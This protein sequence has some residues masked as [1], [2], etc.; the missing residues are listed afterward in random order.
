M[1]DLTQN[2]SENNLGPTKPAKKNKGM[3]I[4]AVVACV[5]AIA[6]VG[7]LLW[8]LGKDKE[9]VVENIVENDIQDNTQQEEIGDE[10]AEI[11][12]G[13]SSVVMPSD[14]NSMIASLLDVH[15]AGCFRVSFGAITNS[16][17]SP[18]QTVIGSFGANANSEGCE[19]ARG[20]AGT[21]LYRTSPDAE[22]QL[23]NM[24][25]DLLPCSAY[26]TI[27]RKRA[28]ADMKCGLG[29]NRTEMVSVGSLL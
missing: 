23:F 19:H 3:I 16:S 26:D 18:Y 10:N 1:E 6:F 21:L 5:F 22:W 25:Q 15:G 2:V 29:D 11:S 28:F 17:I 4:L 12:D 13:A 27:D 7:T 9:E 14:T 8:A 20:G 24:S